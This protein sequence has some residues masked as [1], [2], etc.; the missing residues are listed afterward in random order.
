MNAASSAP[1]VSETNTH[2]DS[3]HTDKES[4]NDFTP[5]ATSKAADS[6]DNIVESLK[7]GMSHPVAV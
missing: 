1:S 3:R 6:N 4:T 7:L 2:D 5:D